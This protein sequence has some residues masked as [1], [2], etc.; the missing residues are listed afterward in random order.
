MNIDQYELLPDINCLIELNIGSCV[1]MFCIIISNLR[2]EYVAV[3]FNLGILSE[4]KRN[5]WFRSLD[6]II[7]EQI[8][9]SAF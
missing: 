3:V 5:L 9:L 1:L 2:F 8:L 7:L 4:Y 6:K